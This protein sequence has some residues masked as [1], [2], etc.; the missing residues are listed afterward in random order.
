MFTNKYEH[1]SRV[2]VIL[3]VMFLQYIGLTHTEMCTCYSAVENKERNKYKSASLSTAEHHRLFFFFVFCL[4]V[5]S[6]NIYCRASEIQNDSNSNHC[7]VCAPIGFGV[8]SINDK[9]IST[10]FYSCIT[11]TN[12]DVDLLHL[13]HSTALHLLLD[14]ACRRNP[15]RIGCP[16]GRPL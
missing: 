2:I 5:A 8:D 6:E 14:W 15:E 13:V 16:R 11:H 4:A 3:G 1:S 9:F 12:V 10:T 7:R